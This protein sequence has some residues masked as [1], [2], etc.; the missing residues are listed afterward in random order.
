MEPEKKAKR[1]VSKAEYARVQAKRAERSIVASLT[2]A[3]GLFFTCIVTPLA[4]TLVLSV[5]SI[6]TI[7]NLLSCFAVGCA[8]L[9][10]GFFVKKRVR[11]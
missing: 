4:F 6:D 2:I 5:Q 9:K 11:Y 8:L 1:I 10:L 3:M 7:A